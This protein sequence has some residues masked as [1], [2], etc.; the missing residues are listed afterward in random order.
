MSQK[1]KTNVR[2]TKVEGNTLETAESDQ[3]MCRD[4]K[5]MR[6]THRGGGQLGPIEKSQGL[7]ADMPKIVVGHTRTR[8]R[9]EMVPIEALG[10]SRWQGLRRRMQVYWSEVFRAIRSA[11]LYTIALVHAATFAKSV[12][13]ARL[14]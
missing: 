7:M 3:G 10:C 8:H 2:A 6:S 5:G 12:L 11:Y 9:G 13:P 14:L 4:G 1:E